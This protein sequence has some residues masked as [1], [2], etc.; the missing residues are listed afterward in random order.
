MDKEAAKTPTP[1]SAPAMPEHMDGL[2]DFS[3]LDGL[4]GIQV[5]IP[6]KDQAEQIKLKQKETMGNQKAEMP[7]IPVSG[8]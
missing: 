3:Q 1:G 6:N 5:I 4:E 2:F 7:G 8:K